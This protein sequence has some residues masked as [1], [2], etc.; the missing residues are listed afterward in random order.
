MKKKYFFGAIFIILTISSII[1]VLAASA[2][3]TL[4]SPANESWTND[5][6]QTFT[7]NFTDDNLTNDCTLWVHNGTLFKEMNSTI[8]L[9]A[10]E[11]IALIPNE[12]LVE[13]ARSWYI[14]C[15]NESETG[16]S[17]TLILNVDLTAPIINLAY[18]T[19]N[20]N[21]TSSV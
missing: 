9:N 2:T 11:S 13:G 21:L 14:N 12:T 16:Q 1:F 15:T 10:S 18:P 20:S 7:F 6:N 4:I 3:V 17:D 8:D 5:G 19:N